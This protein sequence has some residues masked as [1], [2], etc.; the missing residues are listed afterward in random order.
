MWFHYPIQVHP[1]HTDYAGIV[2]HGA[3]IQ[4][5]EEARVECLRLAGVA[6][7]D[8]V[9]IGCDLP[10][11]DLAIRYRRSLLMGSHAI[12]KARMQTPRGVRLIWD[13]ELWSGDEAVNPVL[14]LTA[15]VTLVA[16]DRRTG[17]ILRQWPELLEGALAQIQK[18]Y[19][20]ATLRFRAPRKI[21]IPDVVPT[22]P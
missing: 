18:D 12:L 15:Q 19:S 7:S 22:Q 1:H 4:W 2:W 8:L 17:K 6:F 9:A 3:Y 13:Y 11:V 5:L 21:K 14:H 10:V 20:L 16:I